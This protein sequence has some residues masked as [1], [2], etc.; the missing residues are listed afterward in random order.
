MV[1]SA[2][3]YYGQILFIVTSVISDITL[4]VPMLPLG[5]PTKMKPLK[6]GVNSYISGP[7]I[8]VKNCQLI[9]V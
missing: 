8:N 1:N 4:P 7:L 2:C 5:A 9:A 6:L 3:Q